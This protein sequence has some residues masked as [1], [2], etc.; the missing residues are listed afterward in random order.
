MQPSN[1][2]KITVV[3]LTAAAL[4]LSAVAVQAKGKPAPP[5]EPPADADTDQDGL[6]DSEEGAN[7][8]LPGGGSYD[9]DP[10][11]PDLFASF[12]DVAYSISW[13]PDLSLNILTEPA[14]SGLDATVHYVD[15]TDYG[16]DRAIILEDGV[17][18]Q[19]G[20]KVIVSM[21]TSVTWLGWCGVG[22]PNTE[23]A[24]ECTIYTRRVEDWIIEQCGNRY[25]TENCVGCIGGDCA[26]EAV[27]G[28]ALRDAI[29]TWA[30]VHEFLH[31]HNCRTNYYRKNGG[32]HFAEGTRYI[33]DSITYSYEQNGVVY[34]EIPNTV[35]D[36]CF[37]ERLLY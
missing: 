8:S 1:C 4:V 19:R 15:P 16:P 17:P 23:G 21:S 14:G 25:G 22:T 12:P 31:S 35:S 13:I 36:E 33:M 6:F 7:F 24:G 34:F 3:L 10:A 18:R 29:V 30:V 27:S 2:F 26:V 9:T 20:V 28:V 11:K 5:P 32:N 37:N